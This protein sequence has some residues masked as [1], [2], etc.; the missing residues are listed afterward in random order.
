LAEGRLTRPTSSLIVEPSSVMNGLAESR[1]EWWGIAG[2]IA[3][4][5]PAGDC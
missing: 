4:G 3:S 2:K 5:G 1:L